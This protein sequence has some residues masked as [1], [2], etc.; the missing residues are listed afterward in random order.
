MYNK[1]GIRIVRAEKKKKFTN[2][3]KNEYKNHISSIVKT[4]KDS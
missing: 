4:G 1:K 2:I 3:L